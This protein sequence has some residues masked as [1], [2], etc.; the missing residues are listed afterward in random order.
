MSNDKPD[1]NDS[2]HNIMED[3][4]DI[5][6]E[7]AS[8][9]S[10]ETQEMQE[11]FG[12][13][14]QD[15]FDDLTGDFQE[16]GAEDSDYYGQS[17]SSSF[18]RYLIISIVLALL[19]G[20]FFMRQ[21]IIGT[22]TGLLTSFGILEPPSPPVTEPVEPFREPPRSVPQIAEQ[23][24]AEPI[25]KGPAA[26]NRVEEPVDNSI[27]EPATADI[28][29]EPPIVTEKPKV[30]S[31]RRLSEVKR[32]LSSSQ[33][34]AFRLR[35]SDT[36]T[37]DD[38]EVL[39]LAKK[40]GEPPRLVVDVMGIQEPFSKSRQSFNDP[41]VQQVRFGHHNTPPKLRAVFDL[42][43]GFT[44]DYEVTVEG[45]DVNVVFSGPPPVTTK[46]LATPTKS[47]FTAEQKLRAIEQSFQAV[48]SEIR[49]CYERR[50]SENPNLAGKVYV[51]F[52]V[53]PQG[54]A[55]SVELNPGAEINDAPMLSCLSNVME[56]I[57]FSKAIAGNTRYQYPLLFTQNP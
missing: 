15:H 33:K 54:T 40:P 55:S 17:G 31:E 25:V 53:S 5:V 47:N 37:A 35:V 7:E 11:D 39:F 42:H 9:D 14:A 27:D 56:R 21:Y 24:T 52:G 43:P 44:G 12:G 30:P 32:Q 6:E 29:E 34:S 46:K 13:S 51:K 20:G 50:L 45:G 4:G 41:R 22:V 1:S 8:I 18:K 49:S 38:V 57:R 16:E 10:P 2:I 28:P 26:A 23:K 3:I 36:M 19:G 48:S